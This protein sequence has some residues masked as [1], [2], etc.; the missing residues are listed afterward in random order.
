[1]LTSCSQCKVVPGYGSGL[2]GSSTG[3]RFAFED[4]IGFTGRDTSWTVYTY[5]SVTTRVDGRV[6]MDLNGKASL[7][8]IG[9]WKDFDEAGNILREGEY[10]IGRYVNCCAHGPCSDFYNY[11]LGPWTFWYPNGQIR[12]Q[13]KFIPKRRNLDTAC[14]GGDW[15]W[16]GEIDPSTWEFFLEDGTQWDPST[17]EIMLLERVVFDLGKYSPLVTLSRGTKKNKLR[18][19]NID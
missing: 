13:G 2:D 16:F 9:P 4:S 17:E 10:R 8:R 6:A 18:L 7:L 15:L 1:M 14:R 5:N 11:R 12:A 3:W 19:G